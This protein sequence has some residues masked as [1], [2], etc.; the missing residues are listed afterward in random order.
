MTPLPQS[1]GQKWHFGAFY[2]ELSPFFHK[3]QNK[4]QCRPRFPPF[5]LNWHNSEIREWDIHG[6]A[7]RAIASAMMEP[8]GKMAPWTGSAASYVTASPMP[9]NKTT[10]H[11]HAH[12]PT[13]L[14]SEAGPALRNGPYP[15][16]QSLGVAAMRDWGHTCALLPCVPV[17][18]RRQLK[19]R[20][21][22]S[23]QR[24]TVRAERWAEVTDVQVLGL[25]LW[26]HRHVPGQRFDPTVVPMTLSQPPIL[27]QPM[28][29]RRLGTN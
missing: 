23:G 14:H 20:R 17:L 19:G 16:S 11:G 5:S 9:T 29:L 27:G 12:A 8:Q 18:R 25:L 13:A 26:A 4:S 15:L 1:T 21:H 10:G 28:A 22:V 6:A 7:S 3:N 24:T 2:T